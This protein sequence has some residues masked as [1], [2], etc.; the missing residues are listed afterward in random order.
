[1][2][3]SIIGNSTHPGSK[4]E[5]QEYVRVLE[6]TNGMAQ[7]T[8]M[9]SASLSRMR[10]TSRYQNSKY[11][12]YSSM[13]DPERI[14]IVSLC[15]YD[16]MRTS[17]AT[18]STHNKYEYSRRRGYP[19]FMETKSLDDSRPPAWSKIKAVLKYLKTGTFDWVMW[20]DCDSF[21]MDMDA[22]LERFLDDRFDM[23]L[24]EDGAMLNTGVFFAK[25]SE[26]T[27][28]YLERTYGADDNPLIR[29]P[30]WEQAAMLF[31]LSYDAS[32]IRESHHHVKILTQ[33]DINAY[34]PEIAGQ[35]KDPMTGKPLHGEFVDGDF[36]I[37]FSGCKIYFSPHECEDLFARYHAQS[38]SNLSRHHQDRSESN[39]VTRVV[40]PVQNQRVT[41]NAFDAVIRVVDQ[42]TSRSPH[43]QVLCVALDGSAPT[44]A[45]MHF[46]DGN[47]DDLVLSVHSLSQGQHTIEARTFAKGVPSSS[48]ARSKFNVWSSAECTIEDS[49]CFD[50]DRCVDPL[51]GRFRP[52]VY[53]YPT[54][55]ANVRSRGRYAIAMDALHKSLLEHF[56]SPSPTDA[57]Y[58]VVAR[59]EDACLLVPSIDT[60]C[61]HNSCAEGSETSR[62]LAE[63]PHWNDGRNHLIVHLGDHAPTFDSGAAILL[64]SSVSEDELR[65]NFDVAF[66]LIFYRCW[67]PPL[68][69]LTRF[70]AHDVDD[71]ERRPRRLTL[72]LK[73]ALYDVPE[74]HHAFAR[75]IIARRFRSRPESDVAV[76]TYCVVNATECISGSAQ[77]FVFS[78][79]ELCGEKNMADEP[80]YD[81]ALLGSKFVLVPPG[82]GL[83]SYR[84]YEAMQAGAVPVIVGDAAV[85]FAS[86]RSIGDEWQRSALRIRHVNEDALD[87]L[88]AHLRLMPESERVEMVRSARRIFDKHLKS[89]RTA[90][91]AALQLL[92]RERVQSS[93]TI[94]NSSRVVRNE[95]RGSWIAEVLEAVDNETLAISVQVPWAFTQ[96]VGPTISIVLRVDGL[97]GAAA[98]RLA[99]LAAWKVCFHSARIASLPR[100]SSNDRVDV[101]SNANVTEETACAK[102]SLPMGSIEPSSTNHSFR[103]RI[104]RPG[105]YSLRT[106]LSA[107]RNSKTVVVASYPP[108]GG[109]IEF[110]SVD[111]ASLLPLR[112]SSLKR[113]RGHELREK[114]SSSQ[115]NASTHVRIA[116]RPCADD[117]RKLVV[118]YEPGN[119]ALHGFGARFQSFAG[120]LALALLTNRTLISSP[121]QHVTFSSM[122]QDEDNGMWMD[123]FESPSGCCNA[124]EITTRTCRRTRFESIWGGLAA[125]GDDATAYSGFYHPRALVQASVSGLDTPWDMRNESAATWF[126]QIQ[127]WLWRPHRNVLD[128]ITR[129]RE[130]IAREEE[131]VIGLHVRHGDALNRTDR[132]K[133]SLSKFLTA[134][135]ALQEEQRSKGH[136]IRTVFVAS[137]SKKVLEQ[138]VAADNNPWRSHFDTI[139]VNDVVMSTLSLGGWNSE[140][141]AVEDNDGVGRAELGRKRAVLAGI[142]Q[143]ITLLSD[144]SV[145]VGTCMSQVARLAADLMLGN[146][147]MI[148]K[149]V[150]LDLSL[151]ETFPAHFFPIDMEWREFMGSA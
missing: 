141:G 108:S 79:S 27:I 1:M 43:E 118:C 63:L 76:S 19:L 101:D 102:L 5:F 18:L 81:D 50:A 77:S 24:S 91:H 85:P 127:S 25:R 28:A 86:F 138:V 80:S 121:P 11:N 95:T 145:L 10:L 61:L 137:D 94:R 33:R 8:Q 41:T 83:H 78:R 71:L 14:A 42:T 29:H 120:S 139:L 22:P 106:T 69:H 110:E 44:C 90:A 107:E 68:A 15:D 49:R 148:A 65:P 142:I 31:W 45:E 16:P 104:D 59:P 151:C 26:W 92:L 39:L 12:E 125:I 70:D 114:I 36:I 146:G 34:P 143:D 64:R 38:L 47:V 113:L 96:Y 149:P 88:L 13:L 75:K 97:R 111:T 48:L 98:D 103:L 40:Y 147:N 35:L 46:T 23:I 109:G 53:V 32:A 131:P 56:K 57:E 117:V 21:F 124:A 9:D 73:A 3:G 122:L 62:Y 144:C 126:A 134:A 135:I 30:W 136:E 133:A 67:F 17:L 66:P 115:L 55:S 82:E 93:H 123:L 52:T 128:P 130:R 54:R 60:L 132:T 112:S 20:M 37:S 140:L 2:A 4:V 74:S 6:A 58:R 150:A 116:C 105:R 84:L 129:L 7:R 100:R 51:T 87:A 72:S 99:D 119:Y 89:P